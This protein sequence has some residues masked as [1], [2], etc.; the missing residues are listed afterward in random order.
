MLGGSAVSA[1]AG[2]AYR[3]SRS[4]SLHRATGGYP[5][6]ATTGFRWPHGL[7]ENRRK[8][9]TRRDA[10]R[11]SRPMAAGW[12]RAKA[13]TS[14][15][16]FATSRRARRTRPAVPPCGSDPDHVATFVADVHRPGVL[17]CFGSDAPPTSAPAPPI[18][19]HRRVPDRFGPDQVKLTRATVDRESP[20]SAFSNWRSVRGR[21]RKCAKKPN[22]TS[23]RCF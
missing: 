21:Q 23:R 7:R 6:E 11:S 12:T 2:R 13:S 9:A 4:P 10:L 18:Q 5:L 20:R 19:S 8:T 22:N 1:G 3:G 14:P 15:A 16:A 17:A